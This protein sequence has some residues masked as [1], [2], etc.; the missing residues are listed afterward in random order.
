MRFLL[1]RPFTFIKIF[2]I[3]PDFISA[4]D[5]ICLFLGGFVLLLVGKETLVLLGHDAVLTALTGLLVLLS[6][7]LGLVTVTRKHKRFRQ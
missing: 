3:Q 2:F 4:N 6:T 7:G 5:G 1:H